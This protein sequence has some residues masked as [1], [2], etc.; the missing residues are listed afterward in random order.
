MSLSAKS[1]LIWL[2]CLLSMQLRATTILLIRTSDRIVVAAD[3]LWSSGSG[4]KH[5][6]ACKMKRVGHIYF[7]ASTSDVDVVQIQSLAWNAMQESESV[8]EAA[9]KFG[10]QSDVIAKHTAAH[11][12]QESIDRAWGK[13]KSGADVVFFGIEHGVATF[14]VVSLEQVGHS[15]TS[16]KFVPRERRCPGDCTGPAPDTELKLG[17]HDHMDA[18]LR[19]NPKL[20]AGLSVQ[21]AARKLVEIEKKALPDAVGGPIDVL[22]LDAKG[23][24]WELTTGG[25]CSPDETK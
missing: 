20:I 14:V 6:I 25:T 5:L 1:A 7:T 8:A 23:S 13:G 21:D 3:S 10:Q 19:S 2:V 24:H 16:L 22:T 11:A 12:T 17:N 18:A 4:K 15:R 9:R